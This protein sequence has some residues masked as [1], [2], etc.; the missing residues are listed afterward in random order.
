MIIQREITVNE[1]RCDDC[2]RYWLAEIGGQCPLCS[3]RAIEKLRM[4]R[5]QLAYYRANASN[6]ERALRSAKAY[7]QRKAASK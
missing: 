1:R 6:L 4:E 5:D 3:F 7:I 2:G